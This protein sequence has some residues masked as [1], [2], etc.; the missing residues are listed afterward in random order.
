MGSPFP[1]GPFTAEFPKAVGKIG[2]VA[3]VF[4]AKCGAEV[5]QCRFVHSVAVFA[6]KHQY[7]YM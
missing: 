4:E 2:L 3:G 7:H 6:K 5:D 1:Q